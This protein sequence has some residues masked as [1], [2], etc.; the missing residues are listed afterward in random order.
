M[1]CPAARCNHLRFQMK[2]QRRSKRGAPSV[3]GE[4]ELLDDFHSGLRI[5]F[6]TGLLELA[7]S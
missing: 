4:A 7:Q 2:D 1:P 6:Q 3:G 5:K